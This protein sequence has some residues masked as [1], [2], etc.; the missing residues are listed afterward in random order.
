MWMKKYREYKYD[1]D[2][3]FMMAGMERK[4]EKELPIN[5][6]TIMFFPRKNFKLMIQNNYNDEYEPDNV[7][8]MNIKGKIHGNTKNIKNEDIEFFR[9]FIKENK[10]LLIDYWKGKGNVDS[11]DIYEQM[12]NFISKNRGNK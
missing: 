10:T 6:F 4:F 11:G 8:F 7:F 3:W 5:F 9:Q 12:L 2:F 1:E